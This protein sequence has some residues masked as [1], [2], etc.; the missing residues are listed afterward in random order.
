MK[1]LLQTRKAA[2]LTQMDLERETG[3]FQTKLSREEQGI[4]ACTFSEKI[5]LEQFFGTSIDWVSSDKSISDSERT[6]LKMEMLSLMDKYGILTCFKEFHRFNSLKVLHERF[7][8]SKTT[9]KK[10]HV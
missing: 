6:Q 10:T 5:Q 3:I 2:K 8:K 9:R 7:C 1:T 4:S